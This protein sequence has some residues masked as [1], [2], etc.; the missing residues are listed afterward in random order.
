[1]VTIIVLLVTIACI[2]IFHIAD[3]R[4]SST[5]SATLPLGG[6]KAARRGRL[7]GEIR[8]WGVAC[9]AAAILYGS[10]LTFKDRA[11]ILTSDYYSV[12]KLTYCALNA[13]H[14]GQFPIRLGVGVFQDI[15]VP[16]YQF[17][18]PLVY[19]ITGLFSLLC[20]DNP[21]YGLTASSLFMLALAFVGSFKL[22]RYL[23]R[24]ATLGYVGAF[25]FLTAPYLSINRLLRGAYAEFF[26]MCLLPLVLYFQSRLWAKRTA[27]HCI[28]ATLAWAALIHLHLIT[29]FFSLAFAAFFVC[30]QGIWVYV[31]GRSDTRAGKKY[32]FRVLPLAGCVA[33]ALLISA[34][35]LFPVIFYGDLNIKLALA[36]FS[37]HHSNYLVPILSLVSVADMFWGWE[38]VENPARFQIGFWLLAGAIGFA[39]ANWR[40]RASMFARPLMITAGMVLFLVISPVDIFIG[41]LRHLDIAQFTYRYLAQFTPLGVLLAV[42]AMRK[43]GDTIPAF[44][45]GS[46]Y[47]A[48]LTI[49]VSS[50]LFV[51]PYLHP[52]KDPQ[53]SMAVNHETLANFGNY[54]YGSFA[55]FRSVRNDPAANPPTTGAES[56]NAFA[57]AFRPRSTERTYFADLSDLSKNRN[58][59]GKVIFNVL[60]YPG[61]QDIEVDLDGKAAPNRPGTW[62]I[63]GDEPNMV[64]WHNPDMHL[65]KLENL[66]SEGILTVRVRFV[67]SKL[68][69]ILS[70]IGIGVVICVAVVSLARRIAKRDSHPSE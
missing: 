48:A 64:V 35:H 10:N 47:A 1:M 55:Y 15:G 16:V 49:I 25:L 45:M 30:V 12:L 41:P 50:I 24:S 68:G 11:I 69:N 63:Y 4:F 13:I 46:R 23:A 59:D 6:Q 43:I 39:Y 21:F 36:R 22:C 5:G 57:P 33:V 20:G 51:I 56:L 9:I 18:S 32:L 34:W 38:N 29:A 2:A 3:A 7:A 27:K 62:W 58:W 14:E 37:S 40:N 26:G 65:L 42:L 67:G 54:D 53:K 70:L 28:H 31:F 17:Y 8:L 19:T 66:P 52:K 44:G 60:Y 61:M